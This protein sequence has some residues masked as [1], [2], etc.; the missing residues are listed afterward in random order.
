LFCFANGFFGDDALWVKA[1][2]LGSV[3]SIAFVGGELK[4]EVVIFSLV[5]L[6]DDEAMGENLFGFS[7]LRV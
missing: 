4:K 3:V 7:R 6:G 2:T 1:I 5:K